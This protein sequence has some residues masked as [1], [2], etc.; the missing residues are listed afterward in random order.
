MQTR[1]QSS[2]GM[3]LGGETRGGYDMAEFLSSLSEALAGIVKSTGLGVVRFAASTHHLFCE[4]S[5]WLCQ[6]QP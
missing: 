2:Q 5:V 6:C 3:D 1:L 4:V